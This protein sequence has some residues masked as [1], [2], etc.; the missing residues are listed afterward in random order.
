M[1]VANGLLGIKTYFLH[2]PLLREENR[3]T[4]IAELLLSALVHSA[5]L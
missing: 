3:E 4:E 2:V 5:F 1:E